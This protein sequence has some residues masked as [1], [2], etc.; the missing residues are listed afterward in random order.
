MTEQISEQK[1]LKV[2]EGTKYVLNA[3]SSEGEYHIYFSEIATV[4]VIIIYMPWPTTIIPHRVTD[5]LG[6]D[7][8]VKQD[9][10][11]ILKNPLE[12]KKDATH[13][14]CCTAPLIQILIQT[15]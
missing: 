11:P 13:P 7:R 5:W 1:V 3:L 6:F 14:P 8:A 12:G 15:F 4:T 2:Q 10:Y 9:T